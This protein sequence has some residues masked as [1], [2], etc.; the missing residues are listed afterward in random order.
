[1]GAWSIVLALKTH[2]KMIA[3]ENF[4]EFTPDSHLPMKKTGLPFVVWIWPRGN[5]P[6]GVRVRSCARPGS[7]ELQ[8]S[9]SGYPA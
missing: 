7:R 1:M 5:A 8:I 9:I 3:T 2:R 6:H 4:R